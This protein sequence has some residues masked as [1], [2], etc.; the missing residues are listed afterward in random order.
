LKAKLISRE[1][2]TSAIKIIFFQYPRYRSALK[3]S[4]P[5]ELSND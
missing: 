1:V 5:N 4:D 2:H 3:Q